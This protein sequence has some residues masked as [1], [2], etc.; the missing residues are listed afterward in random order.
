MDSSAKGIIEQ[1]QITSASTIQLRNHPFKIGISI[2]EK[3]YMKIHGQSNPDPYPYPI[4]DET[5]NVRFCI[6]GE[7]HQIWL[8]YSQMYEAFI[9]SQNN[10][11][12][13]ILNLQI[14]QG[15]LLVEVTYMQE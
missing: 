15:Y 3:S 13:E 4:Q 9:S 6:N 10:N 7:Q 5:K 8:G 2:G 11:S 12:I 14:P 1:Y